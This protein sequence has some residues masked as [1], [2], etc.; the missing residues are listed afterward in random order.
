MIEFPNINQEYQLRFLA[1]RELGISRPRHLPVPVSLLND[2]TRLALVL[3][4]VEQVAL[5]AAG[6][7]NLR[8]HNRAVIREALA[9]KPPF[10][11]DVKQD[12]ARVWVLLSENGFIPNTEQRSE[13]KET[14]EQGIDEILKDYS[15][16]PKVED[17]QRTAKNVARIVASTIHPDV[18]KPA[19]SEVLTPAEV[20]EALERVLKAAS[21]DEAEKAQEVFI[22]TIPKFYLQEIQEL[23]NRGMSFA[24]IV[25]AKP[26]L[27]S[28]LEQA[29]YIGHLRLPR[30]R[31]YRG[32]FS[33]PK[34]VERE[35]QKIRRKKEHHSR[36]LGIGM[37]WG[38]TDEVVNLAQ[39]KGV[40]E[41]SV[42]E[43]KLMLE[44]MQRVSSYIGGAGEFVIEQGDTVVTSY[45]RGLAV[46]LENK[47]KALPHGLYYLAE[48]AIV[49][50][51]QDTN[52]IQQATKQ[53]RE[54]VATVDG[55]AHRY[56]RALEDEANRYPRISFNSYS[57]GRD[58][59]SYSK[60][61]DSSSLYNIYK[62][63]EY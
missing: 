24:E 8:N 13:A 11:E 30:K 25:V 51:N 60:K 6:E 48:A 14:I 20:N 38:V 22:E 37:V 56:G 28:D 55:I 57:S 62:N 35:A 32:R 31:V 34:E 33:D 46:D 49:N 9:Y 23:L 27:V 58:Y 17:K 16:R 3:P 18:A 5:D 50:P 61:N 4:Q 44:F 19:V 53:M 26:E 52:L 39:T 2:A 63:N 41:K 42:G 7:R 21:T 1:P 36:T 43:M 40:N 45:A 12:L 10:A 29:R 47:I 54:A 59:S 15:P